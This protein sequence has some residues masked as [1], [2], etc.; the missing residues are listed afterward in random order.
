MP[1]SKKLVVVCNDEW[2]EFLGRPS[3]KYILRLLTGLAT[4][5]K[6]TQ[7]AVAATC[8]PAIHRLEQMSSDEHVGSVAENLL[9]A[10]RDDPSIAI[11]V[12]EV[13]RQTRQ[14]KKRL[15]METRKK[16]LSR[17]GLRANDKE[18]ITSQSALLSQMGEIAEESGLVCAICLEGYR[19]QPLKVLAIYTFSKRCVVEEFE[20]KPHKTPGYC[21]VSHFNVVHVDCYLAA[22]RSSRSRDE[23]ECAALHNAN[24]RANGL[25]PLWGPQVPESAFASCLARH[26]TYLQECTSHRDISYPSTLQ[27]LKLLLL[28]FANEKSFSDDTG[29][30]GRQSNMNLIPYILHM[31]VYVIN[32]TRSASREEKKLSTF[33]EAGRERWIEGAYE[34]EGAFYM[35]VLAL[36]VYSPQQWIAVRVAYL[37][38]LLVVAHAR[39]VS[40]HPPQGNRITDKG[41]KDWAVYKH[42][43][44]FWALVDGIYNTFFKKASAEGEWCVTVAEFVRHNDQT[45]IEASSKLLSTYQ[46]ELLPLASF[47]EF[48]DVVGLLHEIENPDEFLTELL[49]SL[50]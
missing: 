39:S 12:Q 22:V 48:C 21:T 47:M 26:N 6:G 35:G 36:A 49:L 5:H 32:T 3:L 42:A 4:K 30:G 50:P 13:R 14:E 10:L 40:P 41:T 19:C 25:L 31:A 17:L 18:Q 2:K 1:V 28:R 29:G 44:M 9:E 34:A 33:L 20:N 11:Q 43:A 15:A 24:T 38:R 45:L 27:D 23:W 8:I 46:E 7:Q 37:Q 16:E